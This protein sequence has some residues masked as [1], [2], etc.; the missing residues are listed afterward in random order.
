[1]RRRRVIFVL[2]ACVLV[3]IAVVALRP[4]QREPE[5]NGKTL[6]QWLLY[7]PDA[8]AASNA[9]ALQIEAIRQIGQPAVPWLLQWARYKTPAWKRNLIGFVPI[10]SLRPTFEH[11]IGE[12]RRFQRGQAVWFAFRV[13]GPKAADA[14]P[15]L[16]RMI[17]NPQGPEFYGKP[18]LA[19]ATMGDRGFPPVLAVLETPRHINRATAARLIGETVEWGTNRLRAVPALV[20]CLHDKEFMLV[21]AADSSLANIAKDQTVPLTDLADKLSAPRTQH[22]DDTVDSL[23]K[24]VVSQKTPERLRIA[25]AMALG[26]LG[27]RAQN[28]VPAL[29]RTLND[30]NLLVQSAATN[31]LRKIAPEK[32]F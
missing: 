7:K 26:S 25:A 18:L 15:D 5:Y 32:D 31:A 12:E 19:L 28:A 21:A 30:N 17:N 6:S 16:T 23:T 11:F 20:S 3:A 27:A 8:S 29:V 14:I 2:A 4:D 24:F 9:L 22:I 1:V 13:L 10:P